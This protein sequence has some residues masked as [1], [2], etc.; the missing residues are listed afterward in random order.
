MAMTRR[1]TFA[2]LAAMLL[3]SPP[4]AALAQ[5]EITMTAA[6][7]VTVYAD[8]YAHEGDA[9]RAVILLFHQ[10]NSNAQEYA[11]IAPRLAAMGFDAV[12]VDQRSGGQMFAGT[13]RTVMALGVSTAYEKALADMEAVLAHVRSEDGAR[14]VIVWGSSYS[15]SLVFELAARHPDDVAAVMAFSPGEYFAALKV[16]DAA[17]RVTVPVFV[18]SASNPGEVAEAKAIAEAVPG[19]MA[20][21]VVPLIGAHGS[22]TLREDVNPSGTEAN[23]LP[24]EAFLD[25]VAPAGG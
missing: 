12:A 7:G 16:G 6:D 14:P 21:Q 4:V 18:T 10:A 24:V 1:S 15:A 23:W 3:A 20:E 9:A 19:G 25:R 2:A 17:T 11:T 13:N 5:T 8:L 22:S